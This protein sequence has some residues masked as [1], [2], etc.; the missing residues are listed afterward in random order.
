MLVYN[1][2]NQIAADKWNVWTCTRGWDILETYSV[3]SDCEDKSDVNETDD[4]QIVW[5]H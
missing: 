3:E 5:N 4:K 2:Q 1:Q